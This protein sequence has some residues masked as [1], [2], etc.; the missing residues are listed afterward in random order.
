MTSWWPQGVTADTD[1]S[2]G[3]QVP[4]FECV[5]CERT[6]RKVYRFMHWSHGG[7]VC[8]HCFQWCD[9]LELASAHDK[10]FAE[11]DES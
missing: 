4:E 3:E 9:V 5:C 6:L 8:D 1:W 10:W 2:Y 7:Q 11:F